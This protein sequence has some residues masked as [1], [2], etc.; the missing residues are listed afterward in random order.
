M[1][2][3]AGTSEAHALRDEAVGADVVDRLSHDRRTQHLTLDVTVIGCVAHIV[4]TVPSEQDRER[5]RT[6]VR[7]VNGILAAWDLVAVEG[8][9]ALAVAD[10]GCGAT[11]QVPWAVGVDN[12]EQPGVDVVADIDDG[13][14]FETA[15]L[16]HVFA[17]HILEHVRDMVAVMAELHRVLRPSGLLHV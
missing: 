7:S 12:L 13:L 9:G 6:V 8:S 16:D 15:S 1:G 2:P 11:K 3:G 5:V 4:G 14:P 10:I 17:V